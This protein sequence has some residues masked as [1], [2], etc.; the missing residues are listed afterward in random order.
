MSEMETSEYNSIFMNTNIL[1]EIIEPMNSY[2]KINEDNLEALREIQK[3]I[4]FYENQYL[5]TNE[6]LARILEFYRR[7]VP[8]K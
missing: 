1:E 4:M 5:T 7:F 3:I 6:V 8:F 2:N